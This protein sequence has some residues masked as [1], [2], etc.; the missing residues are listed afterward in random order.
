MQDWLELS[1]NPY[2]RLGHFLLGAV[3]ALVARELLLRKGRIQGQHLLQFV[4]VCMPMTLSAVYEFVEWAAELA[5]GQGAE[6]FLGIQG[7]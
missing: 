2:A 1:R 4:C 3:S 7:D 5:L 6:K